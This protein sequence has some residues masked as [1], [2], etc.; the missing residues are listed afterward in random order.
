MLSPRLPKRLLKPNSRPCGLFAVFGMSPFAKSDVISWSYPQRSRGPDHSEGLVGFSSKLNQHFA[1]CHERL[2]IVDTS[3]SGHQPYVQEGI[4]LVVNGEIYNH[5]KLYD[6]ISQHTGQPVNR[7]GKSDTEVVMHMYRTFGA[8]ATAKSLDGMFACVL[9]DESRGEIFAARDHVGIKPLYYGKMNDGG[10]CFASE[11]KSLCTV[12]NVTEVTEF[13]PGHFYTNKDGFQE[14]NSYPWDCENY[15]GWVEDEP[16]PE[17]IVETLRM[18]IEKRM[19]SDVE[20]GMFMSGG[21]DSSILG[22]LWVPM[23]LERNVGGRKPLTF[24]VGLQDS[25]DLMASRAMSK[26]LGTEHHEA[27]FT[28]E[29]AFEV[30]DRVI[31]HLETYESE[32][33]RA[34]IPNWF[35][36]EMTAKHVKMVLTGEGS[37]ELF[38]GYVYFEDAPTPR[39]FQDELRRIYGY[40]GRVNLQRTDRMTMAHSL[41]ARVP[42]LDREFVNCVMKINPDRK[43]ITKGNNPRLKEKAYLR[44]IFENVEPLPGMKIPH[45]VLWRTKAMQSE[46]VGENWASILQHRARE[47]ISDSD[48]QKAAERFPHATPQTKEEYFYR[49]IYDFYYPGEVAK[50]TIKSWPGGCRAG[51]SLWFDE[52]N[53]AYTREGLKDPSRLTHG[54][55]DKSKA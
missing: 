47:K 7:I 55:Q 20:Y 4:Q 1:F 29:R 45:D 34:A 8:E 11:L 19:M 39:A 3:P 28:P 9:L 17:Q 43:M 26:T 41:E 54:L 5:E 51:G 10:I 37:D 33:I 48:M 30:I 16:T 40:L 18:S 22:L 24:T 2:S 27:D 13:P 32:L 42:F 36:A 15:E 52:S 50:R 38:G 49:D 23:Y 53:S 35:L 21:L 6:T 14:F 46:G 12:P 25:P 31:Y 44:S